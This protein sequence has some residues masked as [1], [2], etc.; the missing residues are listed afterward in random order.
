MQK[1]N[2]FLIEDFLPYIL[3]QA[4][5]T[6]SANFQ[7][8]YKG[9]YGILRTEWRVLFHLGNFGQMT[10]RDIGINAKT[11]KTKI[12]RAVFRLEKKKY[13]K[14]TTSE[15]DRRLEFLSLTEKGLVVY[16]DLKKAAEDFEKKIIINF[17]ESE[18]LVLRRCLKKLEEY[19]D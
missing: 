17:T 15:D 19:F 16:D 1:N 6:V 2:F 11:H 18:V 5:E 4:A 9:K 3:T 14:R 10:A 12:S 13:L 8:F 7:P